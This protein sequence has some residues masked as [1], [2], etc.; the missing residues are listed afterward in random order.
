MCW[1]QGPPPQNP[2]LEPKTAQFR[3]Q[4]WIYKGAVVS[5]MSSLNNES[6]ATIAL[7]SCGVAE[8]A[9]PLLLHRH[10]QKPLTW[11]RCTHREHMECVCLNN[12]AHLRSCY[13]YSFPALLLSTLHPI[14]PVKGKKATNNCRKKIHYNLQ[15]KCTVVRKLK[16]LSYLE[17]P[18]W[19]ARS[20]WYWLISLD[21]NEV[22]YK[23]GHGKR[24]QASSSGMGLVLL[25]Q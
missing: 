21:W 4:W 23:A 9:E 25:S 8:P 22:S 6:M 5:T 10:K 2:A 3:E 12:H 20:Q 7:I 17:Q 1:R 11:E 13:T 14:A 15:H 16:L 18:L 19:R 24:L